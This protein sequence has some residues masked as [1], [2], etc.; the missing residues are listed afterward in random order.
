MH[1]IDVFNLDEAEETLE[2]GAKF[3][4]ARRG[5]D[6]NAIANTG[7]P[8]WASF[9]PEVRDVFGLF[10]IFD[11]GRH[12]QV[13][14]RVVQNGVHAEDAVEVQDVTEVA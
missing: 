11:N 14:H 1:I 9:I 5:K 6:P 8:E 3:L 12:P 2:L 7:K 13:H 10:T 4:C